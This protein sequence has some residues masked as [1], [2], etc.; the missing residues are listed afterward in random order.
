MYSVRPVVTQDEIG[1]AGWRIL[2]QDARRLGRRPNHQAL[3]LIRYALAQRLAGRN[4]E[5]TPVQ[6]DRLLLQIP[7]PPAEPLL[8]SLETV[9]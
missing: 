4:V 5:L 1:A 9:A 8:D 7:V 3:V 6:I 2:H